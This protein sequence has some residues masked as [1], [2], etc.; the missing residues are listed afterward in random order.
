MTRYS[1]AS[2]SA[3]LLI[4]LLAGC[5]GGGGAPDV[6]TPQWGSAANCAS[7][8]VG[9]FDCSAASCTPPATY[10]GGNAANCIN[11]LSSISCNLFS[12]TGIP[13]SDLPPSCFKICV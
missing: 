4:G 10:N 5:G 13:F 11:G 12:S 1:S 6:S 2:H 7:Q 8:G 3:I 9:F